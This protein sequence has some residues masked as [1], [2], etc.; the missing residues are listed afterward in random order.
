VEVCVCLDSHHGG[1]SQGDFVEVLEHV[2]QEH[3]RHQ[4]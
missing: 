3:Q 1:I 4:A 2:S